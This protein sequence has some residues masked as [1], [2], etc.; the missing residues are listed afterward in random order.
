MLQVSQLYLDRFNRNVFRYYS[1]GSK[2]GRYG[3]GQTV[4]ELNYQLAF[5]SKV[6]YRG[7]RLFFARVIKTKDGL[8]CN[9]SGLV[10]DN[11]I[12]PDRVLKNL[13]EYTGTLWAQEAPFFSDMYHSVQK[14]NPPDSKWAM[15]MAQS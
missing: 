5:C 15:K 11:R 10:T 13:R 6:G 3:L 14:I 8:G 4:K 1:D 2:K 9:N 12:L 7:D